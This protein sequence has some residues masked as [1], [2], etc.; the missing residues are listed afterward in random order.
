M[1]I[2]I[3]NFFMILKIID[4]SELE[5]EEITKKFNKLEKKFKF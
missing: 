2:S 5:I 1:K 4:I 3:E